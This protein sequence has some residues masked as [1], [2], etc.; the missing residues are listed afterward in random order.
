[1]K[2]SNLLSSL[3]LAV[4]PAVGSTD[5]IISRR[6]KLLMRLN[7]QR[8][9]A[10]ADIAG[11]TFEAFKERWVDDAVTGTKKK[12]RV[13]KRVKRWFFD[14]NGSYFFEVRYGNKPLELAK[15]KTAIEVG[16]REQVPVVIDTIIEAIGAGELDDMLVAV[17]KPGMKA[18]S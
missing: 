9:F 17:K 18:A 3:N 16:G 6:N 5:P 13:A 11:E 10:C 12:V 2:K 15:G 8:E 7:E 14:F 4:K 1:M